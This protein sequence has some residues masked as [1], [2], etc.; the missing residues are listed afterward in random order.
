MN[1]RPRVNQPNEEKMSPPFIVKI[2]EICD[3]CNNNRNMIEA[4][5]FSHF[6]HYK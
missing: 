5:N 4:N 3:E 2:I 6:L 1:T